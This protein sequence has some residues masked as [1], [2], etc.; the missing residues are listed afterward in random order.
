MS[1]RSL[2]VVR[3]GDASLH[4]KWIADPHPN[5]DL[6]VSYFGDDATAAH[7]GATFVH[8]Y[9]GGKWDGLHASFTAFPDVVDHY[10]S[11]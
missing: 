10:F 1:E 6:A 4:R 9:K 11:V 2:V 5:W 3:A 8:R 7:Q